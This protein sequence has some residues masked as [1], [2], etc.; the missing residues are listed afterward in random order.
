[1]RDAWDVYLCVFFTL[2]FASEQMA[3]QSDALREFLGD[4]NPFLW[5]DKGS[6]DPVIWIEFERAYSSRFLAGD[7]TDE[8]SLAFARKYLGKQGAHYASVFPDGDV[9]P[10]LE[11][12]DKETDL[13]EWTRMLDDVERQERSDD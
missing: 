13:A 3:C 11:L 1:M 12:F 7:S 6:A 9:A 2:E 5:A 8:A 4:A 10:F